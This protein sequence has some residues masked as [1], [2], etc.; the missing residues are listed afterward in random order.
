M[1]IAEEIDQFQI[2]EGKIDTLIGKLDASN[3]ERTSLREQVQIQEEKINDLNAQ[4]E[5]LQ[6]ARDLAKQRIVSLLEKL[7]PI[8]L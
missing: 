5:K 1:E 2:L 4:V 8:E 3:R 7:E 6:A